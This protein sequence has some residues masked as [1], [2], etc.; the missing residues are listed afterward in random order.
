MRVFAVDGVKTLAEEKTSID[1]QKTFDL[2]CVKYYEFSLKY[3]LNLA[4]KQEVRE[5]FKK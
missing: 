5:E 2:M 3:C 4:D 1:E